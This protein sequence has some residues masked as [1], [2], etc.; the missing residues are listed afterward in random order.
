MNRTSRK[1]EA[2]AKDTTPRPNRIEQFKAELPP[3]RF[4]L[5][6]VDW[7][8]PDERTRFYLKN[9]GLYN[10]KLRPDSWMIRLRFDSGILEAGQ[11]ETVAR[12]AERENLR[13]LLTAR[14]QME[15]HDLKPK[16]VYPLWQELRAAGLTSTQVLT[17][18]LR[19][20]LLDPLDQYAPD[21]RI[22]C[23]PIVER[24][25]RRFIGN[26]Q[27][28]GTLPRKFNAALI[29]R[30][31]PS[32]N[33]WGQDLLLALAQKEDIRGFNLYLGGKNS[34]TAKNADI[35]CPPEEAEQLFEAV[36]TTYREYGLRGSRA[37]TRLYHLIESVGMAQLRTWIEEAYGQ[38]LPCAG[39]LRMR[40]ST[41][42]NDHFLS[43]Q[44]LGRHGEIDTET[45]SKAVQEARSQ[46][47]TLRLTPHQELWLFD[48]KAIQASSSI[49][50]SQFS[51]LNSQSAPKGSVIACA[52]SRY[53]PLSLWEIKNDTER[54]PLSILTEKGISVGFSGCLKGCGRH[55]H[56]DLG[57]VGLRSNAFGP[58]ERALRVFVG[59]REAPDPAPA[60][61]LFYAVPERSIARLF[62]V[63]A[64]DFD[65]SGYPRFEDLSRHVLSRYSEETLMLWYLLRQLDEITEKEQK[66]F[67]DGE[68]DTLR[69]KLKSLSLCCKMIQ[70]MQELISALSHRLWN[71]SRDQG[72]PIQSKR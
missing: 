24:L 40:S 11:L 15:L 41:E 43:I 49:P 18:N 31:T 27:W 69:E 17:D 32:F 52:G 57:L 23:T 58:T 55:H 26:P 7:H 8:H 2:S 63:I 6:S 19:G 61:L 33:P 67:F 66:L 13:V 35:F 71:Q 45:L 54:L 37:K 65:R 36:L 42:N 3:A 44:R 60:R 9:Y 1:T 56:S 46:N 51:I 59:A 64:E 34:E 22:E 28:I 70:E 10:I 16:R 62:E 47:L 25:H 38:K 72:Q 21:R 5:H 48:P 50:N 68:E 20:I 12:I 39:E 30:E 4:D 53:C 29:G 14:S